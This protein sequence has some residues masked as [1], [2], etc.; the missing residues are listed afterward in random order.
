MK[1]IIQ[2]S[3]VKFPLTGIG[4]YTYELAEKLRFKFGKKNVKYF[5]GARFLDSFETSKLSIKHDLNILKRLIIK[6]QVLIRLYHL[7][8]P[9]IQGYRLMTHKGYVYHGPNY[10]LPRFAG[11]S[12]VTIHDLSVFSWA[13][14]HPAER[15]KAIQKAINY[16]VK[17]ASMLITDSEFVRQEIAQFYN[18]S[19]DKIVA[20]PL[21]AGDEFKPRAKAEA[22]S[23]LAKYSLKF[24]KYSLFVST[25]EPRKNLKTLLEAYR[26]IPLNVRINFP[27]IIIGYKGWSSEDIHLKMLEAEEEGWLRYIGFAEAG[28]L[29]YIYSGARLFIFP[30]HYEG[31]GLPVLEAMASGIPVVCS[32]SSS[33]PEVV[34][35]AAAMC[36]PEDVKTLSDLIIVGLEND[37][38]RNEAIVKG[39][40]QAKKFSWERCAEETAEVYQKVIDSQS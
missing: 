36:A 32:N 33:I 17:H 4:R 35:D 3:A 11:R 15:V 24:E 16:S 38:W 29:P 25:I 13:W 40:Q 27:L 34:G 23:L 21:A 6:T 30:S 14:C 39:L 12:V 5:N 26:L 1:I 7:F 18:I 22:Q 8:F 37:V 9:F 28:D 19:L 20:I 31:F 2:T 10:Y